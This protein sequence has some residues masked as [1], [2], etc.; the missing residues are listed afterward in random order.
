[1]K[2]K[3]YWLVFLLFFLL[4]FCP[5]MLWGSTSV[6]S[7]EHKIIDKSDT[8]IITLTKYEF[9][10]YGLIV[11]GKDKSGAGKMYALVRI[12]GLERYWVSETRNYNDEQINTFAVRDL[13]HWVTL[14]L[15]KENLKEEET[16]TGLGYMSNLFLRALVI[17]AFASIGALII[18]MWTRR[19]HKKSTTTSP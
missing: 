5:V 14:K 18:D 9:G 2:T 4:A 11:M 19:R 16:K 10:D 1:M 15:D 3:T 6:T 13:S 8:K 7:V 12:P 17:A